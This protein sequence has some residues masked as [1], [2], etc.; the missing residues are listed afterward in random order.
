MLKL[1][2]GDVDNIFSLLAPAPLIYNDMD[3][4]ITGTRC[5]GSILPIVSIRGWGIFQYQDRGGVLQDTLGQM[6]AYAFNFKYRDKLN[7][8]ATN[9]ALSVKDVKTV[10]DI[11]PT[12]YYVE[13]YCNDFIFSSKNDMVFQTADEYREDPNNLTSLIVA[14]TEAFN[15]MYHKE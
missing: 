7:Y 8:N 10:L 6:I 4:Y 12:P 5:D 1:T 11:M 15:E 14:L 2:T 13:D 9:F 3:Q